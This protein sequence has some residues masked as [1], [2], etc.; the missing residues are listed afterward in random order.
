MSLP[1]LKNTIKRNWQIVAI[2]FAVLIIY[3]SIVIVLFDPAHPEEIK[4]MFEVLPPQVLA[5]FKMSLD[6]MTN[7]LHYTASTYFGIIVMA[8]T[9]VFYIIQSIRLV[10]KP[11]ENNSL[12]YTL[13][14][15]I[16]RTSFIITQSFYLIMS[17]FVLFSGVLVVGSVILYTMAN[18]DF[19]AY[20]N[21]VSV[22]FLL[23]V[24]MA[25][26]TFTISVMF[27]DSKKGISLATG[28][29]ISLLILS[30]IAGL[31]G[32]GLAWLNVISPFGWLDSVAIVSGALSTW[33]MYI[34]FVV[35]IVAFMYISTIIFNKKRLPL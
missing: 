1:L 24:V 33:W 27:C 4:M 31:G 21:L 15:P 11:V 6:T 12:A 22:T 16:S 17:I 23:N 29:P 32:D 28:V 14:L 20:L 7:P 35:V 19:F 13:S 8:F 34:L 18:F 25:M 5:M 9:M 2:F 30:M 3:L 26:L 10:A